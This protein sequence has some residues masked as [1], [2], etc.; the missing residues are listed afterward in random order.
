MIITVKKPGD[1]P[2][3]RL[4]HIHGEYYCFTSLDLSC[5][6]SEEFPERCPVRARTVIIQKEETE[7]VPNQKEKPVTADI[8]K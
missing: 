4:E 7:T 8:E 1:C 5:P 2:L 6:Y 3:R